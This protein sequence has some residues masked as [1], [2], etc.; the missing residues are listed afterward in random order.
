MAASGAGE[1]DL[2]VLELAG[3]GVAVENGHPTLMGRGDCICPGP[4]D[5]GVAQVL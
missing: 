5:D 3:Y 2:E 1:N 4:G